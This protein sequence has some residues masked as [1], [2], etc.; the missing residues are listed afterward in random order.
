MTQLALDIKDVPVAIGYSGGTSSQWMV[1]A[2]LNGV[3]PRPEHLA[4]FF[5]DAGDE[6]VWTYDAVDRTEERC[7]AAGVQFIRTR[8]HRK[9]SIS[10]SILAACRGERTRIDNPPFW[11]ENPGGGRGR[12]T[13]RC[14][15]IWKSR[16]L[17][18]AQAHWLALSGLKKR[19]QTWIGFAADEVHRANKAIARP[20]V[21]WATLHF[22]AIRLRVSREQQRSDVERWT[23]APAPL[24]SMCVECPFKNEERWKQT[25]AV[26]LPKALE[27]DEAIRDGMANVGVEEPCYLSD[28]LIPVADLLRGRTRADLGKTEVPGCDAG[29]CF[30]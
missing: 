5:A 3:I 4:V 25:S 11:T 9:E 1:D 22:P 24:F 17:R 23:G 14:T 18:K 10:E 13:Q 28:R 19:A 27:V 16:A 30:L 6:H 21:K 20:E 8:T 7:R 15:Q 26:D 2:V 29:M 12:L